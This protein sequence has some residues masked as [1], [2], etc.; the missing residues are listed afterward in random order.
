[1]CL[2][3]GAVMLFRGHKLS[4]STQIGGPGLPVTQFQGIQ[5][6]PLTSTG[7][8]INK[9]IKMKEK[10]IEREML[11]FKRVLCLDTKSLLPF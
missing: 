2:C 1:M 5:S 7:K 10:L 11:F 8:N 6:L 4:P 9:R 3:L